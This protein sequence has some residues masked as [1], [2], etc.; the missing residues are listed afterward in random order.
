[1]QTPK[2]P[3]EFDSLLGAFVPYSD[4]I[5]SSA[6]D[7]ADAGWLSLREDEHE[8]A[9]AYLDELLSGKYSE[10]ELRKVWRASNNLVSPFRGKEGSCT[11]FLEFLRSRYDKFDRSLYTR[12]GDTQK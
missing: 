9:K 7:M 1:M 11:E 6:E 10:E 4:E 2:N 8:A 3:P 5:Y 12:N